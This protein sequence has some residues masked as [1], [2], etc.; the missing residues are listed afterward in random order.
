MEKN[1]GKTWTNEEIDSVKLSCSAE[2]CRS[3]EKNEPHRQLLDLISLFLSLAS[4]LQKKK[5]VISVPA[6]EAHSVLFLYIT[7][8]SLKGFLTYHLG[9]CHRVYKQM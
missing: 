8:V 2:R 7:K 6:Q 9:S 5:Q 1:S 3:S 4:M